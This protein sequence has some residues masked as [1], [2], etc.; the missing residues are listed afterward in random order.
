M[1]K[2]YEMKVNGRPYDLHGL[3]ATHSVDADFVAA[4]RAELKRLERVDRERD[5]A[6]HRAG[7]ALAFEMNEVRTDA[8]H[9]E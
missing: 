9:Q 5:F 7:E 1:T 8:A 3:F 6:G 4:A 2:A